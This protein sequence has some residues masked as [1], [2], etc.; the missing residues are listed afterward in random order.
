MSKHTIFARGVLRRA[1]FTAASRI[2][3]QTI[4]LQVT[5]DNAES[6]PPHTWAWHDLLDTPERPVVLG[7]N[8][9]ERVR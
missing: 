9:P 4:T 3:R 1:P 5:F 7:Y 6:S 8:V 2:M